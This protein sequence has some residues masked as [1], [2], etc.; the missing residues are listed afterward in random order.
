MDPLVFSEF[1]EHLTDELRNK[2]DDDSCLKL[3]DVEDSNENLNKSYPDKG[4]FI[5][6]DELNDGNYVKAPSPTGSSH[7]ESQI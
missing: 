6:L 2:D 1:C 3:K 5:T 4:D 7:K